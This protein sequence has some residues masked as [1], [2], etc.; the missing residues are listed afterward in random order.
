[1]PCESTANLAFD[2]RAG[3]GLIIPQLNE[4]VT[5]ESLPGF[6]C[7]IYAQPSFGNNG[8]GTVTLKA[9]TGLADGYY[10]CEFAI[11]GN[12]LHGSGVLIAELV[13]GTFRSITSEELDELLATEI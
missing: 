7:H 12:D 2:V 3:E 10:Y 5:S 1:M 4:T 11:T 13:N 9:Q 8:F 6:S